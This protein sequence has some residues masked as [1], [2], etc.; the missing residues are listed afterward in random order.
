[1]QKAAHHRLYLA[2][3]VALMVFLYTVFAGVD[4]GSTLSSHAV[5]HQMLFAVVALVVLCGCDVVEHLAG[6][7][8]SAV[9]DADSAATTERFW[10]HLSEKNYYLAWIIVLALAFLHMHRAVG[11]CEASKGTFSTSDCLFLSKH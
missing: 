8:G 1:V 6:A 4:G 11:I 10:K 2:L 3:L 9:V 5:F 7:Y